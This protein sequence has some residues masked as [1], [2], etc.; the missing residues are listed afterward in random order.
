M[1]TPQYR[2]PASILCAPASIS[3]ASAS[4]SCAPASISCAPA[5]VRGRWGATASH[6]WPRRTATRLSNARGKARTPVK[7]RWKCSVGQALSPGRC[8]QRHLS[9]SRYPLAPRLVHM[10]S[11]TLWFHFPFED[12]NDEMPMGTAPI[13]HARRAHR[14]PSPVSVPQT[15]TVPA[16]SQ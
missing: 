4:I 2:A 8:P 13:G 12:D 9:Y 10:T 16:S 7:G 14:S 11:S 5:S 6:P 1:G 3:C 15:P